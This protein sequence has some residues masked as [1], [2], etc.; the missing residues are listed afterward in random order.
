MLPV[1]SDAG[2]PCVSTITNAVDRG[3]RTSF[4]GESSC[5]ECGGSEECDGRERDGSEEYS[6]ETMCGDENW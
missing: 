4:L 2:G 3:W 6:G 1:K 5:E